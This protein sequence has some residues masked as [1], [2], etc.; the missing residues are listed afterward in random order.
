MIWSMIRGFQR[1]LKRDF[2]RSLSFI[3]QQFQWHMITYIKFC[4]SVLV[5]LMVRIR[6][7]CICIVKP[8][9]RILVIITVLSCLY[10]G[11][12]FHMV[13]VTV[14]LMYPVSY[15]IL[16]NVLDFLFMYPET[17]LYSNSFCF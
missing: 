4:Q 14:L 1:F 5:L 9:W 10:L 8:C 2:H 13:W 6:I 17:A 3:L 11:I 15:C 12:T 16:Q 7:S